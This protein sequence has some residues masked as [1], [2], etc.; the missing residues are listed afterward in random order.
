MADGLTNLTGLIVFVWCLHL[1]DTSIN[2]VIK[3][4]LGLFTFARE[5]GSVK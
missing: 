5:E 1:A 2:Y 3:I 4:I